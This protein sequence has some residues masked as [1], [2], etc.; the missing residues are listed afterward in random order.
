VGSR[1]ARCRDTV[2][3][4]AGRDRA[5]PCGPGTA[6]PGQ[7]RPPPARGP[8]LHVPVSRE[9]SVHGRRLCLTWPQAALP[10]PNGD[11]CG[12]R[13]R[14]GLVQGV[15]GSHGT[16]FLMWAWDADPQPASCCTR[17]VAEPGPAAAGRPWM[18]AVPEAGSDGAGGHSNP[19]APGQRLWG[20]GSAEQSR[21]LGEPEPGASSQPRFNVL[22]ALVLF[23]SCQ[24]GL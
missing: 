3:R 9:A 5:L 18:A 21:S 8:L 15:S 17:H 22:I 24:T 20:L 13:A 12:R 19:A 23:L 16:V 10:S 2:H 14:A 1:R 6:C 7:H 11:C 4:A